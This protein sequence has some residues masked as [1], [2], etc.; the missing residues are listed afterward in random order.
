MS[1]QEVIDS[2][3]S[4]LPFHQLLI[5]LTAKKHTQFRLLDKNLVQKLVVMNILYIATS[6]S[7]LSE[8]DST[9]EHRSESQLL[10]SSV[11]ANI[12]LEKKII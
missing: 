12:E 3:H 7:S 2:V 11:Y 6:T 4:N 5:Y 9:L 8:S 10:I 1:Q